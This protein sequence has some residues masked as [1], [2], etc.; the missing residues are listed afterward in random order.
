MLI[1]DVYRVVMQG[2]LFVA[3]Y[4]PYNIPQI[5]SLLTCCIARGNSST[6]RV[7]S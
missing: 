3:I 6:L 4:M 7:M 1:A 2:R 5:D